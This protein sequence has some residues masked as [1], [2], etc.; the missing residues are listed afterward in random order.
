VRG[1]GLALALQAAD[2]GMKVALADVDECLLAAAV[3][4]VKAKDVAAIAVRTGVS[5]PAAV[6]M[7]ARR[8]EAEL[9]PPWLV[10]N[11]S[12][13]SESEPVRE[14]TPRNLQWV[15]DV[16][17][18]G[19]INGVQVFA[20]DMV[21]R[22]GGHIVNIAS[23]DMFGIPGAAA[24]VAATHAI[25]GLSESLYRELDS[26]GSQVGVTVV[27]PTLVN[28]NVTSANHALPGARK[29]ER[30]VHSGSPTV[31]DASPTF[32]PPDELAE[33]IFAAVAARRFWLFPQAHQLS[34]LSS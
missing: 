1:I 21:K 8:T 28:T 23:A 34:E 31:R 30:P 19:V 15:V 18:W 22:D 16:N 3:E 10:C 4:Q 29:S 14:F 2:K 25:M 11:N 17:L 27:C 6:R 7:L 26:I 20:P 24:Y 32:L 12:G 9:G 33:R 13:V 5:D